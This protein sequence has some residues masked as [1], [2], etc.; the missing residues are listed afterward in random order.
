[1]D[2][3]T[4]TPP[5]E[6]PN[7]TGSQSSATSEFV[8]ET[9]S[10]PVQVAP[11][12]HQDPE[13]PKM[14]SFKDTLLNSVP[15]PFEEDDDIVLVQGDVSVDMGG[16]IPIINF[17]PHV[18]ATLNQK[19]GLAVVVK[20]LGRRISYRHLRLQLQHLWKPGGPFK[21]T[22]LDENCFIVRFKEDPDYQNALLGGPWMI[23]GH[24]L[25]V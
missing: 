11:P 20:L 1:M 23:F 9:Q 22:D 14:P 4:L 16:A 21:L 25:A 17:A 12:D 5:I 18:L 24:Y 3:D 15:P 6:L 10:I 19:M 13:P 2:T 7:P 8:P